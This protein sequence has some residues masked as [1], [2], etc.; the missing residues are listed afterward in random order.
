VRN[1]QYDRNMRERLK[2]EKLYLVCNMIAGLR[3]KTYDKSY[4]RNTKKK[5][6]EVF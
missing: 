6:K 4:R 5:D 1:R 3:Y 2:N